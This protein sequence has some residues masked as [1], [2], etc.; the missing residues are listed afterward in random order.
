MQL[1]PIDE[2]MARIA[3]TLAVTDND[4]ASEGHGSDDGLRD[5]LII[6]GVFGG[7]LA[8][9]ARLI[10]VREMVQ[11]VV[12]VSRLDVLVGGIVRL[13]VKM[14]DFG[15]V[16]IDRHQKVGGL[17]RLRVL[18]QRPSDARQE[19]THGH[20]FFRAQILATRMSELVA[21]APDLNRCLVVG[22]V[23][24]AADFRQQGEDVSPF[25]VMG[26]RMGEE[27]VERLPV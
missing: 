23:F 1:H 3:V 18:E 10:L 15:L 16:M 11:K 12:G 8:F 25:E 20:H 22:L 6:G 17:L 9:L 27:G 21:L 2:N 7:A 24:D 14:K 13:E 26:E 5:L 4:H 19:M